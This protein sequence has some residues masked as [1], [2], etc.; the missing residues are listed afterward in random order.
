[1]SHKKYFI[2]E[3]Y[4]LYDKSD[5][6]KETY[7]T[8]L[9]KNVSI[10]GSISYFNKK[11]E[12]EI[13][14]IISPKNLLKFFVNKNT[15][16]NNLSFQLTSISG[17]V[18]VLKDKKIHN[19][20]LTRLGRKRKLLIQEPID[21]VIIRAQ[22]NFETVGGLNPIQIEIEEDRV[23]N[24]LKRYKNVSYRL[25]PLGYYFQHPLKTTQNNIYYF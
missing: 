1:M 9:N 12:N 14:K 13:F 6:I 3:S 11:T 22:K 17:N 18:P 4:F 25:T 23:M 7:I 20:S 16:R 21:T 10:Y 15:T 8:V 5:L 2:N 19:L 24:L